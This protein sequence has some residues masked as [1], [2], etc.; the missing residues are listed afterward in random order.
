MVIVASGWGCQMSMETAQYS[1]ARKHCEHIDIGAAN[2]P[3]A[4]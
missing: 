1:D 4:H 2:R 3:M